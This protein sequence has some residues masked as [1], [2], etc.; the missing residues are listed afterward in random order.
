M[1]KCS[2][3]YH[4]YEKLQTMDGAGMGFGGQKRLHYGTGYFFLREGNPSAVYQGQKKCFTPQTF[5]EKLAA[6]QNTYARL[7][8]NGIG[9]GDG[10]LNPNEHNSFRRGFTLQKR[11]SLKMRLPG[12]E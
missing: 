8:A 7:Q 11:Y 10:F 5:H 12:L 9:A 4:V 2:S 3:A 6:I 1:I